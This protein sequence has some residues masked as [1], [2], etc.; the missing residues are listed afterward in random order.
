MAPWSNCRR[1]MCLPSGIWAWAPTAPA[2]ID[3]AAL[4]P[5]FSEAVEIDHFLLGTGAA[6]WFVPEALRWE[7]RDHHVTVEAMPTAPA[8]RPYNILLGEDR[9]VAAGLIAV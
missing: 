6:P 3:M 9:R 4:A 2:E 1:D 5:V 7:L 8:V